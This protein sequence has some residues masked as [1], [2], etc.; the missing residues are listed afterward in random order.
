MFRYI[1][2]LIQAHIL[3]KFHFSFNVHSDSNN[4]A[5]IHPSKNEW[6]LNH[7][8]LVIETYSI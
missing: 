5:Q 7:S 2:S 6:R 8:P 1:Q 4:P 3:P